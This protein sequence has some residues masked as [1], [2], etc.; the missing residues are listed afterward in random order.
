[1]SFLIKRSIQMLLILVLLSAALFGLLAAMPGNPVDLLITSNPNVKPED[2][3]RLKKLRG[4]DRPWYVQYYRWLFGYPEPARPPQIAAL[5]ALTIGDANAH[6]KLSFDL[7]SSLFDPNYQPKKE[8]LL[9]LLHEVWPDWQKG[10]NAAQ[11][12]QAVE[13]GDLAAVHVLLGQH[14]PAFERAIQEKIEIESRK[15]LKIRGLFGA[16]VEGTLITQ[17]INKDNVTDIFFIVENS[18]GQEKLGRIP[19]LIKDGSTSL[20]RSDLITPIQSQLL[21]KEDEPFKLDLNKFKLV[22]DS[23]LSFTGIL[24]NETCVTSE[25][26]FERSFAQ[27][28]QSVLAF[29]VSDENGKSQNMAFE[30]ERGVIPHDSKFNPGFLYFFTG[31]RNALGFSQTYKRPV[32]DILFGNPTFCGDS[33]TDPGEACDD[34]NLE[35]GDG[36]DSRCFIEGSSVLQKADVILSGFLLR[37]GRIGNT[38][39]LMLPALLLSLLLA[40]PLGI[41]SAYRQYSWLDYCVNFWLLWASHCRSFGLAS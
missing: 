7:A 22:K 40:I 13:N 15:N 34:G 19:V 41:F 38:V 18:Y 30:L 1:M 31:N 4:L 20:K 36:C 8:E 14:N 24:G 3:M 11:F 25:G 5:S 6:E 17:T 28:G 35:N 37:S 33:R 27:A 29:T 16:L 9:R 12:N 21:P 23:K 39:Q 2:I 26:Q 32:Y 10:Q